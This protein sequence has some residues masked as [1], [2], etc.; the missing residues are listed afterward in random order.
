M[1]SFVMYGGVRLTEYKSGC[2]LQ[3][4]HANV[5]HWDML[6][7]EG[8][9]HWSLCCS[10]GCRDTFGGAFDLV[11][12]SR[13]TVT[14]LVYECSPQAETRQLSGLTTAV[15]SVSNS[16]TGSTQCPSSCHINTV[17]TNGSRLWL[18]EK[19]KL[20]LFTL[21]SGLSK[22]GIDFIG[23]PLTLL[24]FSAWSPGP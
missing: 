21:I 13:A 14:S 24:L 1:T 8:S 15:G 3:W 9:T 23:T 4:P 19:D 18:P 10:G 12:S 17:V 5:G 16:S 22:V 20:V 7:R 2:I 6:G 11:Q